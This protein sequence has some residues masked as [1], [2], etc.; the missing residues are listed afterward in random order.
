MATE[1]HGG[2][3]AHRDPGDVLHGDGALVVGQQVRRHPAH[4]A[5][6]G[7]DRG[8]HAGRGLV[9]QRHHDPEPAPRQPETEQDRRRAAD[10]RAVTEVVLRPH[11]RLRDPRPVHPAPPGPPR[12]LDLCDR[13]AGGPLGPT[14]PHRDDLVV[15]HVGAD[16]PRTARRALRA[17]AGTRRSHSG[18][19]PPGPAPTSASRWATQSP[20]CSVSI[21][22]ARP[23]RGRTRS[24]RTL[25]GF[26]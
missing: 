1:R 8:E 23:H 3:V 5:Q 21:R 6:R 24:G 13:A 26:P 20:P 25:L 19:A 12:L 4:H 14:E 10:P 11:P 22:P 7:V 17:W 16:L 15:R 9:Q 18:R 2:R